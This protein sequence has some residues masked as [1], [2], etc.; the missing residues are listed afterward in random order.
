MGSSDFEVEKMRLSQ[1]GFLYSGH[2]KIPHQ[3]S[4]LDAN[5]DYLVSLHLVPDVDLGDG[6]MSSCTGPATLFVD[7][8]AYGLEKICPVNH[9]EDFIMKWNDARIW[10]PQDKDIPWIKLK[11]LS[12]NTLVQFKTCTLHAGPGNGGGY[13]RRFTCFSV[14]TTIR[15]CHKYQ[16]TETPI[17]APEML[18]MHQKLAKKE[19]E[20]LLAKQLLKEWKSLIGEA[21][22]MFNYKENEGKFE[23]DT[24]LGIEIR[25][26]ME[27]S[28]SEEDDDDDDEFVL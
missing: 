24:D 27:D 10:G 18:L 4:H 17:F 23:Q 1:F 13:I 2:T 21:N 8:A 7:L 6:K 16:K 25:D 5:S 28:F 15:Y 26:M 22:V 20:K 9:K 12:R 19:E 14:H 3:V 11:D